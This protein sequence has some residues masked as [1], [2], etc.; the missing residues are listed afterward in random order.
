MSVL[1]ETEIK[2]TSYKIQLLI[3]F[4][5]HRYFLPT[6]EL[7]YR[8]YPKLKIS[9]T[10]SVRY[11]VLMIYKRNLIL[12]KTLWEVL[13]LLICNDG[14]DNDN[15]IISGRQSGWRGTFSMNIKL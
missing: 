13:K 11:D 2:W 5:V 1:V 12:N 15:C 14:Y 3:C 9:K 10:T 7:D 6:Q 4:N 8:I